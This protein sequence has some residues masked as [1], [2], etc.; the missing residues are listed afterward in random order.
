MLQARFGQGITEQRIPARS[1]EISKTLVFEKRGLI[2]RWSNAMQNLETLGESNEQTLGIG[3]VP[4]SLNVLDYR[5]RILG[6]DVTANV[7]WRHCQMGD[8]L[9]NSS[10]EPDASLEIQIIGSWT[11]VMKEHWNKW[12]VCL[13]IHFSYLSSH[14]KKSRINYGFIERNQCTSPTR[15][16]GSLQPWTHMDTLSRQWWHSWLAP[17]ILTWTRVLNS[18]NSETISDPDV[19]GS[20][21]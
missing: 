12:K 1:P 16:P 14:A 11:K 18:I 3:V 5:L 17:G 2:R 9:W 15:Q 21:R 7:I 13:A 10:S 19:S 4:S 6:S 20:T 8:A